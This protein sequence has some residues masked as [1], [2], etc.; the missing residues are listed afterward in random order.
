VLFRNRGR[1]RVGRR[2]RLRKLRLLALLTG[3]TLVAA[4]SFAYGLVSAIAS[5]LNELEPGNER[6]S[7]RLGYIY[8]S[9]G[10]T[11]LAVLRGSE[12]RVIVRSEEIAPVMKQ[13]I[14]AVEDRRF[15]EHS[16]VDLRGMARAFWNDIREKKVVQGGSTITQ[17]FVK[18]QYTGEERTVSRKLKEAA[19]AWQLEQRWSKDRILTAYLNT[20]YFGNSAYGVEVASRVYFDKHAKDLTLPEAALLAGLAASPG[21][22]DPSTDRRA[23]RA[24]R[25]T[26]LRLMLAQGL[27][28]PQDLERANAARLPRRR[29]IG[30]P[31]TRGRV[32]HFAEY[33]KQQL[34]PYYGSGTVFG[35]G[36]KVYTSIDLDL[37]RIARTAI[38]EWLGE[39]KGPT[40]ALVAVR[41]DDGRVVAM[42]GGK[43]F[44]ASQFNLAVQGQRQTGSAFK[45][46]VLAAALEEGIS[47]QTE[48]VSK[49]TVINLGDKL[50]S[51]EN[52]EGSDRG[53]I[54]LEEATIHS[55][56]TVYAQLTAEVGPARV[57]DTARRLGVTRRL[58]DYFAIGLGVEAVSPLEMARA[59]ASFAAGGTRVDGSVLGNAP[60][61]VLRVEDGQRVD[62]NDPVRKQ[63]IDPNNAAIVTSILEG[64]VRE[65]TG[66]RARLTGREEAGKTGTTEH[67]GDAWFVGYTP[68][69]AVAVWVGYPNRLV[70]METEFE[71][72]PVAGGT[73]PAL[74]WKSFMRQALRQL[75]AGAEPFPVPEYPA[76]YPY[77]V[78]NRDGRLFLDNGNCSDARSI[79]YFAGA[80]PSREADCKPN[81]V[82]V[83]RVVGA[84]RDRAEARL[85]SM[86]L[87]P[88][89][90]WRPAEP[91]ER[92]D[93]VTAQIPAGGTL[94]SWSKVRIV[95]PKALH[96]RVPD[97]VGLTLEAA[98]KKLARRRLVGAVGDEVDGRRAGL[99][100]SQAP[101]AGRA[102]GRNM[103]V[104]LSVARG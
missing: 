101:R 77:Q 25:T 33:V 57:A 84:S 22:Y 62:S 56:N 91:G 16:G 39:Q 88:E 15:W 34:I 67:Y 46:F 9:D 17:Q 11:V 43:S 75:D 104:I 28:G 92:L 42:V 7:D 70:P 72:G 2:R 31:A 60:R 41:P 58:N 83:P 65:G 103:T 100:V 102:A 5:E 53:R 29:D 81:E 35:G 23:A 47:P 97:V 54:D 26:V 30:L 78:V 96:G 18:N 50:W 19:L 85:L 98:R 44:Q 6:R 63:A 52:Y 61:A 40:A 55:D 21:A 49:P 68:E 76:A 71:G 51:V 27:I 79:V 48:F 38:H 86:P 89:P 45:P 93:R 4:V 87:T 1:P 10:K 94:S 99:V 64:V 90:I 24:R 36:L 8:A 66:E 74:I 95:M 73:Y 13:A 59:F 20:I 3:L 12:S 32:Q 37:Q 14:V 69:L 82:D 80:E